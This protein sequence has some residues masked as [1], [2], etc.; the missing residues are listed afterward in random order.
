LEELVSNQTKSKSIPELY[1]EN[2]LIRALV[3]MIPTIGPILDAIVAIPGTKI[4]EKRT[5]DFLVILYKGLKAVEDR[6]QNL[7]IT[8]TEEFY[9]MFILAHESSVSTRSK[10]KLV[11]NIMILTNAISG[12]NENN[13]RSEEYI[14]ALADL[15]PT[16]TKVLAIFY[17]SYVNDESQPEEEDNELKLARRVGAQEKIMQGLNIDSEE[18]LFLLQRLERSGFIR[19]IK[20]MYLGYNGGSYTLTKVLEQLMEYL[21]DHP[22]SK[23]EIEEIFKR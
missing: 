6:I 21:S 20:G 3:Q 17:N 23:I 16:E 5:L 13:Y 19:E 22:F 8:M 12:E 10:E 14:K 18:V 11:F 7:E 9:D 4:K 1:S 2:G 15:T